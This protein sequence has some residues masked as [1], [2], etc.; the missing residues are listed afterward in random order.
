MKTKNLLVLVSTLVVVL[1]LGFE[2]LAQDVNIEKKGLNTRKEN[3]FDPGA[4]GVT[5][6][7][8]KRQD[9]LDGKGTDNA[10]GVFDPGGWGVNKG[11][12]AEEDMWNTT[13]NPNR[14]MNKEREGVFDPGAWG[15]EPQGDAI[16][17]SSQGE[18]LPTEEI[19]VQTRKK[20]E[21]RNVMQN[22]Y[23]QGVFKAGDGDVGNPSLKPSV[24][25]A[26]GDSL[27]GKRGKGKKRSNSLKNSK[28]TGGRIPKKR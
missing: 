19:N 25:P 17:G 28:K 23:K 8:G 13:N 22:S 12:I 27:G 24:T 2:T 14:M 3:V 11:D 1:G 16:S 21:Q 26:E 15:V 6:V 10:T 20:M 18:P 5:D 4:W 9:K 7:S